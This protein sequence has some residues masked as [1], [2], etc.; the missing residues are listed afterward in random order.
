LSLDEKEIQL[1][2]KR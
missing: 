1:E 2:L